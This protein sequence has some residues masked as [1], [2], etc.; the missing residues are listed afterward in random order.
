M[1]SASEWY[2]VTTRRRL[3]M[4]RRDVLRRLL[5]EAIGHVGQLVDVVRDASVRPAGPGQPGT[6]M[7]PWGDLVIRAADAQAVIGALSAAEWWARYSQENG[8]L[9]QI[10]RWRSIAR[11]LGDDR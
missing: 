6:H 8:S 5:D 1:L 11:A 7:T 10:A 9:E 3:A 2:S 4:R